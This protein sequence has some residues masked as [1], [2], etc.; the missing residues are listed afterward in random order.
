MTPWIQKEANVFSCGEPIVA[1]IDQEGVFGPN[2]SID[3]LEDY[4]RVCEHLIET[5]VS[6]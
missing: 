6:E 2:Y 5:G 1:Q 3:T 4:I